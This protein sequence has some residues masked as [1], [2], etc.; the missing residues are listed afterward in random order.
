MPHYDPPTP[1]PERL[2]APEPGRSSMTDP[3]PSP[4]QQR[5]DSQSYPHGGGTNDSCLMLTAAL[6]GLF[7]VGLIWVLR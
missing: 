3:K 5:K 7:M 2:R 6:L 1:E 4:G